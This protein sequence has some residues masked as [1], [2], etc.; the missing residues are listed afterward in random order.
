VRIALCS[1]ALVSA[2]QTAVMAA[3]TADGPASVMDCAVI[4]ELMTNRHE[5]IS[6]RSFGADCDWIKR[7]TTPMTTDATTG[8]RN[9]YYRPDYTP[10]GRGATVEVVASYEGINGF[11]GAHQYKCSLKKEATQWHFVSCAA[12]WIAN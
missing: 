2:S 1:L 3:D 9:F 12:G 11:F 6:A 5:V 4:Q 8:W 7:S 10:D